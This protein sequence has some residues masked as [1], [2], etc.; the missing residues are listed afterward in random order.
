MSAAPRHPGN[1]GLAGLRMTA[2]EY[3]ALGETTE[4][5]E[6]VDGVVVMSPSATPSYSEIINEIVYQFKA[7]ARAADPIRVFTNTDLRVAGD[8]VYRPVLAAYTAARLPPRTATL[9]SP[10]DLVVEVLSPSSRALDLV[11]KR[12]DYDR[13]NV[14]EYWIIDP[15]TAQVRTLHRPAPPALAQPFVE[16]LITADTHPSTAIPGF[17]LDLRPILAIINEARRTPSDE[18]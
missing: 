11:T 1:S 3:L 2:A 9:N 13:F 6:L 17:T 4:R 14:G 18:D 5:Y 8:L 15:D 12:R 10:P 16:T 7:Y